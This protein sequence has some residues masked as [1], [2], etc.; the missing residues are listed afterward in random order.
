[1][2]HTS[3]FI[4]IDISKSTLDVAT[5]PSAEA[6][7]TSND[8]QGFDSLIC[9]LKERP[10][11]LIVL[12]ATGGLEVAL[13]GML[14][15]AKLPVVVVNPRQTRDFAKAIGR[16]AKTD[17]LDALMLAQFA[18]AVRPEVRAMKGD[19]EC[20]LSALLS[21]RRQLIDMLVAEQSRLMGV[22]QKMFLGTL[23]RISAG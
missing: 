8:S 5:Y 4:G 2:K 15:N 20:Y 3:L 14:A 21:R 6:W 13:A 16:L 9:W 11:E 18:E 12:E 7:Q 23:R 10:I 19:E 22:Y 1:M 17:R